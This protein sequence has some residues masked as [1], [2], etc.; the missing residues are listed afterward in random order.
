MP[1]EFIAA[2]KFNLAVRLRQSYMLPPD[3]VL[4]AL[5]KDSL[6]VIRGANTQIGT[7]VMPTELVRPGLY[8]VFS[9]QIY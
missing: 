8:N 6:N 9:D 5:A 3:A 7:L 1:P 2:L 4:V